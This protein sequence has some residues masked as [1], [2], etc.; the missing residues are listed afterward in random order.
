LNS[1]IDQEQHQ[2]EHQDRHEE[3][4][5]V[6]LTVT[7]RNVLNALEDGTLSRK[8]IFEKIG[9]RGDTRA[10]KRYIGPLLSRGFI[11]MTVP[12]KPN[13]KLQRYRLTDSGRSA[14][15]QHAR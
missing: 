7:Q 15:R 4:R 11:K 8:E 14:I 5:Q 2:V 3:K 9:I 12:D 1:I 13:S 10:F 6:E